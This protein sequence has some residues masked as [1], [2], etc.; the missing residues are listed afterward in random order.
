MRL[1][2]RRR[3]DE[4]THRFGLNQIELAVEHRAAGEFAWQSRAGAGRLKRGQDPGWHEQ[5]AVTGELDEVLAGVAVRRRED[6]VHPS[7]DRLTIR[8]PERRQ[9][10]AARGLHPEAR[11]DALR[12]RE[13][14]LPAEANYRQGGAAWWSG[15]GSDRVGEQGPQAF[16]FARAGLGSG[17]RVFTS[18]IALAVRFC[19]SRASS[20]C[21]GMLA[22]LLTV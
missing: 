8:V 20:H 18:T 7:I 1:G 3:I 6:G 19:R 4:I 13:R 21:C 10:G 2:R 12:D 17:A 22:M 5:A 11:D 14:A 15:E 9:G 16:R